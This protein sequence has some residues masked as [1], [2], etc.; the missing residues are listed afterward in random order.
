MFRTA[1][2]ALVALLLT[3]VGLGAASTDPSASVPIPNLHLLL[4]GAPRFIVNDAILGAIRRVAR[5]RCD[6][7]FTEYKDGAG[8]PLAANLAAS[9]KTAGEYLAEL[10][11]ADGTNMRQCD[12]EQV[13]AA[14]RPGSHVIFICG[15]R[16]ERQFRPDL[17]AGE[18]MI[19]HELL[20]S[21]GL[22]ENP[23]SSMEI[24]ATVTARCGD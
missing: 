15:S 21:L 22:G 23:P 9:G 24:T 4:F 16:F 14:T 20:H 17:A 7:V 13:V 2:A 1:I 19:V 6:T 5:P 10:R 3:C 8:Q 12:A 18:I 11:F